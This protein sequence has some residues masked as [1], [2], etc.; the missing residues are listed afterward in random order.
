[1]TETDGL[2]SKVNK[3]YL[4]EDGKPSPVW[5]NELNYET[6]VEN[7]QPIYFWIIDF[8][9]GMFK[10]LEKIKDNFIT[11]PGSG[12][13]SDLGARATKMQE[14]SMK[15]LGYVNTVVKSIINLIYDL[16]EFEMLLKDYESAKSADPKIKET[17]I[18][19]LKQRWMSSVDAKR[20]MGSIDNMAHQYGFTLLRPAFMAAESV[21]KV[22]GMDLNNIIKRILKPRL[23]EFFEWAKLSESELKKRYNIEKSY[24]RNQISTLNL[25]TSW[26]KPYLAAAEQLRMKGTESPGIVS[27]FST[28]IL[29]LEILGYSPLNVEERV[30]AKDL[31]QK[32]KKMKFPRKYNSV[33]VIN[34]AFRTFP[35]QQTMHAGKVSVSFKAFAMND[36]EFTLFRYKKKE[37]DL[38]DM[39]SVTAITKDTLDELKDDIEKY[40]KE[41][42][43]KEEKEKG[44]FAGI[45]ESFAD[46]FGMKMKK[47]KKKEETPE[48]KEKKADEKGKALD[49][50]GVPPDSYEESML[51]ELAEADA[52]NAC[53]KTFDVF[54]KSRGMASFVN[55]FDEPDVM[56]RLRLKRAEAESLRKVKE[57]KE[58]SEAKK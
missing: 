26:V 6:T 42:E 51:R 30:V 53:F 50:T 15:I 22:D 49:E 12:Y 31:P 9:G 47:E 20:G 55:P 43:K 38:K 44:A 37:K 13:F 48:E 1:M 56:S 5:E 57:A 28:M 3:R 4:G 52:G 40:T 33:G 39:F 54:K 2:I 23:S 35:S 14:E 7:L 10:N 21:E 17:G 32:F 27:V 24:L 11:S 45:F 58:A 18:L 19:G 46:T 41:E 29:E 36:D 16:K 25:Y 34:F 8:A